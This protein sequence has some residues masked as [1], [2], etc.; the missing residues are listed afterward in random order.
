MREIKFRAWNSESNNIIYQ[1][2][3]GWFQDAYLGGN[4]YYQTTSNITVLQ[5]NNDIHL[6]QFTGL[7]DKDGVEIYEGDIVNYEFDD[8]GLLGV[9]EWENFR[10]QFGIK[11]ISE[12][13]V[14]WGVNSGDVS[15]RMTI[16]GNIHQ[17]PELLQE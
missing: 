6:M 4:D 1:D 8:G 7:K 16:V 5:N 13:S 9:F 11:E 3:E 17:N 14:V 2:K 12:D 10:A 15:K